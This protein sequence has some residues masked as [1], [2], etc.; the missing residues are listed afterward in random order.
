[1]RD[2]FFAGTEE[3]FHKKCFAAGEDE[4]IFDSYSGMKE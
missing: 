4:E 3:S 2:S 1:M